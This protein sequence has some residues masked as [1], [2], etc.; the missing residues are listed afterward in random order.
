MQFLGLVNH[1]WHFACSAFLGS[2]SH[3][4]HFPCFAFL[5]SVSHVWH[6]AYFALQYWPLETQAG[7]AT[8]GAVHSMEWGD[9]PMTDA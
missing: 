9:G 1:A 5:G 4:W 2:V 3:V 7:K 6:F 8:G